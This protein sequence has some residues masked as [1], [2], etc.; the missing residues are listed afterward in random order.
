MSETSPTQSEPGAQAPPTPV[1]AAP[2]SPTT[3]GADYTDRL[4]RLSNK[5][6]K[7]I[8]N[9]Q[10][11]YAWNTR[12]ICRGRVLDL[13]CGIGRNLAH[14]R[15]AGVG[16]DHNPQSVQI[17]CANGFEA[18]T[19][20]DFLATKLAQPGSFDTLLVAHVLEHVDVEVGD[21]L[22]ARYSSFLRPGGRVVLICPQE[23]GFASDETHVRWVDVLDM[24]SHIG[25]LGG[26]VESVDSFP[27]PRRA[28]TLFVYNE[29]VVVGTLR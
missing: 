29:S 24:S 14:L 19:P 4:D 5:R 1:A 9:P 16:V 21:G 28:G 11:P 2:Q 15:G 25:R 12:R 13:G 26:Q 8:L 22:L 3:A 10:I 6:W 20:E 27:F 23:R 17:A 7:Q 18:Y